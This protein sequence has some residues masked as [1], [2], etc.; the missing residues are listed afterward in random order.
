M[1]GMTK[2]E[3]VSAAIRGEDVDRPPIGLWG[4]DF[5]REWSAEGLAAA[6]LESVKTYDYDFLKVNPRAS[7]YSE[8]WGCRYRR[9]T[10]PDVGPEL[11]YAVVSDPTDLEGIQQLAPDYGPFGEQL[12]ALKLIAD[13]LGGEVPFVQTVFSPLSVVGRLTEERSIVRTWMKEA[14]DVLHAALSAVTDTLVGYTTRSLELGADGIFFPTTEWGTYDALTDDEYA[15]FGR[16]YDLQVLKAAEGA[17]FNIFHVC[18]DHNMLDA[19]LDYPAAVIHWDANGEGN[20]SLSDVQAKTDKAVMGSLKF[21]GALLSGTADQVREEVR[22]MLV[23]TDGRRLLVGPS[24]SVLPQTPP[25][26]IHAAVE[27]VKAAVG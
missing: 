27:V 20:A 1:S 13:G 19:L 4:H 17:E 3:R 9:P 5:I 15:T 25:E 10:D 16:P 11:D 23:Q 14:P 8:G 26:N 22:Q 24:C 7:Y 21:E 18:R 12:E 6:M 2:R